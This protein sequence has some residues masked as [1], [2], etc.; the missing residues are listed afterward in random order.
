MSAGTVLVM[1][2]NAI[3]MDY[4]SLL[5][6]ID[7]QIQNDQGR[8]VP[9]LGYL[10]QYDRMIEKS[11]EGTLTDAET[12][13]LLQKFDPAELAFYEHA[14]E[15]TVSLLESWLSKY[16]FQTWTAHS[17]SGAPVTDDER[18]LRAKEIANQLNDTNLWHTHSRGIGI[19]VLK[20]TL[21]LVIEDYSDNHERRRLVRDYFDL[22]SDYYGTYGGTANPRVFVQS[23]NTFA[24]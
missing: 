7:P 4:Y 23:R 17:S 24:E 8:F 13:I 2:G 16:K 3:H 9:A 20:D 5:G 10:E 11:R 6:P 14:K 21:R 22:A 19:S 1:S 12:V 18:K 15:L